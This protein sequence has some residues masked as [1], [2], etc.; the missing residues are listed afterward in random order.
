M[1][2]D[3]IFKDYSPQTNLGRIGVLLERAFQRLVTLNATTERSET[4]VGVYIDAY[5]G[6]EED[7]TI[8]EEREEGFLDISAKVDI[9][10]RRI[11]EEIIEE[12]ELGRSTTKYKG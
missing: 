5:T 4:R 6:I 2:T 12:N 8:K 3:S 1:P 11:R 7:S 10:T 9:E